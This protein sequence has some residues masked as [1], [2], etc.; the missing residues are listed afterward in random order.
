MVTRPGYTQGSILTEAID[1]LTEAEL[2]LL[3]AIVNGVDKPLTASGSRGSGMGSEDETEAL[4][5]EDFD[6]DD[7]IPTGAMRF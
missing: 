7:S 3:G 1:E 4:E 2:P 6:E 5:P